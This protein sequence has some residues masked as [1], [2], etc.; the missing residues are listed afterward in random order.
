MATSTEEEQVILSISK[1]ERDLLIQELALKLEQT[2]VQEGLR[3]E[4]ERLQTAFSNLH[5][6]DV[7]T[8]ITHFQS[9]LLRNLAVS[10]NIQGS[11]LSE[12][13]AAVDNQVAEGGNLT[14]RLV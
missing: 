13:I 7:P 9:E 5:T 4:Y 1:D 11:G 8:K 12:R 2:P 6:K 10:W 14:I 3:L